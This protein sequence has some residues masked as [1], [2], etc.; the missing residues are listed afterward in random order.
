MDID[1]CEF[2]RIW[3]EIVKEI[4]KYQFHFIMGERHLIVGKKVENLIDVFKVS[5]LDTFF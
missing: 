4:K 5:F 1:Y 2:L 3:L